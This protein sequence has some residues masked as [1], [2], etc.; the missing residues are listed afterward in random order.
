[1][2]R[3]L[4]PLFALLL[5]TALSYDSCSSTSA[6]IAR[7]KRDKMAKIGVFPFQAPRFY[8]HAEDR[9]GPDA[10]LGKQIVEKMNAEWLEPG[11]SVRRIQPVWVTRQDQNLIP[12]LKN[13][14]ADFLLDIGVY[15]QE[16][17]EIDYSTPYSQSN[18]VLVISPNVKKLHPTGINGSKIGIRGGSAY[19]IF[20][21]Q[22]YPRAQLIPYD[23]FDEASMALKRGEVVGVIDDSYVA[24][25]YLSETPGLTALEIVPGTLGSIELAVAMRK[26][27]DQLAK[28]VNGVIRDMNGQY[29]TMLAEQDA[30][31][32]RKVEVRFA[33][34]EKKEKLANAPRQVTIRITKDPGSKVD[35]YRFANL[36]FT[37]TDGSKTYS[38]SPVGFQGRTGV[39]SV[40]VPPGNYLVQL[41]K[42]NLSG[43]LNIGPESPSSVTMNIRFD[44]SG[45]MHIS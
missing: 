36:S 33:E 45:I 42:F 28:L 9:L 21:K 43:S 16:R 3:K 32:L 10:E 7:I 2:L 19:E 30:G 6:T 44:T 13:E 17:E 4:T 11:E 29:T 37:F 35:I 1:M 20:A 31:R 39:A 38:S 8:Q 15:K 23:S 25:Y 26:G 34:R 22:K 5:L 12:A 40:S 14:E 41:K 18:V 24:A 27:D